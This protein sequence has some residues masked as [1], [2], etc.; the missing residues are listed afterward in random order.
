MDPDQLNATE[1]ADEA[2]MST[3]DW[4]S[5]PAIAASTTDVVNHSGRTMWVEI[6]GGTVT[7]VKV[8][9]VTIGARVAG[10][11]LVRPGSA[12]AITYSVAP[13]WQWFALA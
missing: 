12:I 10:M 13:T 2:N 8:D 5:K 6:A 1:A 7:V 9:G 4:S 11:F 3:G